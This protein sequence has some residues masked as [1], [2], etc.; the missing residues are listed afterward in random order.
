LIGAALPQSDFRASLLHDLAGKAKEVGIELTSA[1]AK[2]IGPIDP[3]EMDNVAAQFQKAAHWGGYQ[4][5]PQ[6]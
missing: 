3:G 6:W 1:Q 4:D 2:F 5:W